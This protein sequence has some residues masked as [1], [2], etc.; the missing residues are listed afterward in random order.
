MKD[1]LLALIPVLLVSVSAFGAGADG[2]D[3]VRDGYGLM[4]VEG[5]L[6]KVEAGDEGQYFRF[7]EDDDLWLFTLGSELNDYRGTVKT[8]TRLQLLPSAGLEKLI[9]DAEEHPGSTYRL[10]QDNQV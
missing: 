7:D 8:G 3:L 10:W 1:K 6:S 2:M 5:K 9:A 4:G